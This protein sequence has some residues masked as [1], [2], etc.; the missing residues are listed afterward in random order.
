MADTQQ[1]I[2]KLTDLEKFALIGYIH[3]SD[4]KMAYIA[5][6]GKKLTANAESL[7]VQASRWITKP[8]CKAF[9]EIEQQRLNIVHS[10]TEAENR[11]KQDITRELNVLA[12]QTGD[13]KLKAELLMRLADLEGMKKQETTQEEE[14]TKYYLP[15]KCSQCK[16]YIAAK[17]KL[18]INKK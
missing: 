4:T 9:I 17:D 16:L 18:N 1:L 2:T 15:L 6:R 13:P 10:S 12:T 14:K 11:S 5:S 8:E 3:T 7:V